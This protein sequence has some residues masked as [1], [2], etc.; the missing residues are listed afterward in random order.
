LNMWTMNSLNLWTF[1]SRFQLR[2]PLREADLFDCVIC[3]QK[4]FCPF[5][6]S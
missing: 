5:I 3:T 2:F 1:F 6:L 4:W